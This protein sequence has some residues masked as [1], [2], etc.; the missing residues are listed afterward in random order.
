MKYYRI[1]PD[2]HFIVMRD[3]FIKDYCSSSCMCSESLHINDVYPY[4][5]ESTKFDKELLKSF[6]VMFFNGFRSYE[7]YFKDLVAMEKFSVILELS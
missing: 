3:R 5:Y 1:S 6:D 4:M 2:M 7:Y